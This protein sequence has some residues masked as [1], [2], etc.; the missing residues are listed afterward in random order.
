MS[1][2]SVCCSNSTTNRLFKSSQSSMFISS[3]FFPPFSV[4]ICRLS[5]FSL[6]FPPCVTGTVTIM[7]ITWRH[8][9]KMFVCMWVWEWE[10]ERDAVDGWC[11][12]L[13]YHQLWLALSGSECWVHPISFP[14]SLGA[15]GCVSFCVCMYACCPCLFCVS[16]ISTRR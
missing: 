13:N 2:L 7:A 16:A 10:R 12:C 5:R 8:F 9:Y 14:G 1:Q 4:Y 3:P 15:A 11:K 6:P